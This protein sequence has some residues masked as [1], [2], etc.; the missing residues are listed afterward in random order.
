M[1]TPSRTL[2]ALAL[3][4]ALVVLAT[5]L[6]R[7][8]SPAT[9]T[10]YASPTGTG[11]AC[12]QAAPCLPGSWWP[13]AGPGA[14]LVLLD[15]VYTGALGMLAPPAGLAGTPTAPITLKALHE[16]QVLLDAAHQG[17]AVA[18]QPGNDYFVIEGLNA[19]NGLEALYS[20][21]GAHNLGRRLLGWH[22]TSGQADSNIFRAVGAGTRFEDCA[23]WGTNSRKIFD[24]AQGGNLQGAGY[25]RCWGEWNDAPRG[26][27]HPTNTIQI[28]YNSTNQLFENLVL[29]LDATGEQDE[30][31]GVMSMMHN[32]Y[33]TLPNDMQGTRILGSILYYRP[34][35]TPSGESLLYGGGLSHLTIT[36][37]AMVVPPDLPQVRP[38]HFW[39]AGYNC[40]QSCVDNVC[41]NCLAVHAGLPIANDAGSGFT[42]PALHQGPDLATATGGVS[43]FVLLPGICT[44][45]AGGV[46]TS[47]G[48][49][50]WPMNQ[51]ILDARQASGAP[52]VDVTAT[53]AQL[54]GPIPDQCRW[55]R[56]PIPPQPQPPRGP[57]T[58]ACT[59]TLSS[60]PGTVALRCEQ[61]VKGR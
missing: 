21:R 5:H 42:L 36:D 7:P 33:G 10:F 60:A 6:L 17:F 59:G 50:P 3:L 46:L 52:P 43:P 23:G 24:G 53:V 32:Q 58:L 61:E 28:G 9:R 22:G 49:W 48:L 12:T 57:L 13:L 54:L 19:T 45:Y 15:G 39:G 25:T 38:A 40:G 31:E 55:D 2:G 27:S 35:A 8:R 11:T 14:T 47:Q 18:L 44:R 30:P 26:E 29:T 4:L 56:Q 37:L 1:L 34:G 41:Q 16:G 20:F 51:R